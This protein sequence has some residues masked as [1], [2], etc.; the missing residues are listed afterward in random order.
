ML[1]VAG[2]SVGAAVAVGVSVTVGVVVG[3]SVTVGF[4]EPGFACNS[5]RL[6]SV[7]LSVA[8]ANLFASS[9]SRLATFPVSASLGN[10]GETGSFCSVVILLVVVDS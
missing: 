9:L 6:T 2:V 7:P 4:S 5:S 10:F 1:P 8:V 3:V